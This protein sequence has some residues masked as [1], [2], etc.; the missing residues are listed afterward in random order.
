ME[1]NRLLKNKLDIALS[2]AGLYIRCYEWSN[3]PAPNDYTGR[4]TIISRIDTCN[5][6]N[7]A[8][9]IIN[10]VLFPIGL[11][12]ENK[13]IPS[14]VNISWNRPKYSLHDGGKWFCDEV[15]PDYGY[16]GDKTLM[17]QA[18]ITI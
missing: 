4:T 1:N 13:P 11:K 6:W 7:Q 3:M 16:A 18:I 12:L 8:I 5:K 17:E 10:K 15:T 2:D 9:S 14:N